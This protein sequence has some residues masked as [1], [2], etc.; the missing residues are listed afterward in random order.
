MHHMTPVDFLNLL[1]KFKPEDLHVLLWTL[2]DKRSH[3]YRDI[4]AAANFVLESRGV[5]VYVGVGLSRAD[6]GPTRR[7]GSQEIA[8]IC[9][10][11]ADFDLR[12]DAHDKKALPTTIPDALSV[13]PASMPATIVIAT[14]NGAHAWWLFK[15]PYIFD[16]ADDRLAIARQVAR[17]NTLLCLRASSRGWAFDRLS[18]LARVLRIPGTQ[19]LKDAANPKNVVV[20]SFTDRRYDFADFEDYLDAAAIPDEQDQENAATER[21]ER[22]ADNPFRINPDVRI[23]QETLDGWMAANMRF[24]NTWLR[25]RDDL[26]DQSQSGYDLALANFGIEAGMNEQQIVDLIS[27]HRRQFAQR[28]RTRMD[29]FQRTI[30]RAASHKS[31]G[32]GGPAVL[33]DPAIPY[34]TAGNYAPTG[35]QD[36][37]LAEQPRNCGGPEPAI[38]KAL[39]CQR[40][41]ETLGVRVCRIVKFTGKE[42]TYRMELEAGKLEFSGV[43]K[44]MSQKVVRENIAASTGQI[45]QKFK[46]KEWDRLAQLMLDACMEQDGGEE[47]DAR[48]AAL[49]CI[50]QYLS[51]VAF[52]PG[53]EDQSAQDRRKPIV[54]DDQIAVCASDIQLYINKTGSQSISVQAVVA[55]LSA[56]GA[57]LERVRGPKF[58]EQSRWML[59]LDEFDPCDYASDQSGRPENG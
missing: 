7:C 27:H 28:P 55:M 38:A 44:L 39:L 23:P 6:H 4:A 5:D 26:K 9:G 36:G 20:H 30:A 49:L 24:K 56:C 13:I 47:M 57:M 33:P 35:A 59:P 8:G 45:I 31:R 37:R 17:W 12:S 40:I 10:F 25:Q 42:P 51:E 11:W 3:W 21:S 16:G 29:Y 54:R 50:R 18:D 15:E 34:P 41:S 14:G 52:I 1:W 32:V 2:P 19:N 43:G 22:F 58:K 53:I 46:G 48:G